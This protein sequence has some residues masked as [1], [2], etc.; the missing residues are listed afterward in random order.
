MK[1][2]IIR[3]E[4]LKLRLKQKSYCQCK[5][6][7]KEEYD[8]S[9][10]IRTLMRWQKRFS[11]EEIWDLKDN[12][13][14][15]HTIHNRLTDQAKQKIIDMRQKT[16]WG[17]KKIKYLLPKLGLSHVTI[18]KV[19]RDAQLTRKEHNRGKRAKYIRFQR[20]HINTLWHID[21]SEF[22][23]SGKIIS[24]ID[25]CSRY[26]LGI[27]HLNTI[28]TNIV[29]HFLEE[30]IQKYGS[31]TQIIT[32][33]G[34]PY[35]SKSKHSRFDRWCRK[36]GIEHI[37]T[38]VK[39]PQTNGKIERLFGTIKYEIDICQ[40]LERL[41]YRYNHQRPHESINFRFP[42]EIYHFSNLKMV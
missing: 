13:R 11:R 14:K 37:R 5:K 36:N 29:T 19:I 9:A 7:L 41:R 25:D 2:D 18:N 3:R 15:P 27:L 8:Y 32:D 12:S 35:G 4:F 42:A 17:A 26:C 40:E 38:R 22:G 1:K 16:G 34:S 23:E 6:I 20:D 31:P 21:D 24:I 33:N 10:S 30:L 28:S 39:R